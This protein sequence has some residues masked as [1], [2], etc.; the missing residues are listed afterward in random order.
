MILLEHHC[1][2]IFI[3]HYSSNSNIIYLQNAAPSYRANF[4]SHKA[5][6]AEADS[7]VSR[8]H[9]SFHN[10][11][12][13]MLPDSATIPLSHVRMAGNEMELQYRNSKIARMENGNSPTTSGLISDIGFTEQ[14]A[15]THSQHPQIQTQVYALMIWCK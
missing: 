3:A 13:S 15:I 10:D 2:G 9:D 14:S 1:I 6:S 12:T 11:I 5:F 4:S 8:R 7:S